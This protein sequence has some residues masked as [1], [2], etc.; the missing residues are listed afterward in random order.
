MNHIL[1]DMGAKWGG[2]S[3]ATKIAVAQTVAGQR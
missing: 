1:D 3:D 2:L